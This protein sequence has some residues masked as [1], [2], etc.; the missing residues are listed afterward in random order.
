MGNCCSTHESRPRK[1]LH[2][3]LPFSNPIQYK[4]RTQLLNQTVSSLLAERDRLRR[5]DPS[6]A[7]DVVVSELSYTDPPVRSTT[8]EAKHNLHFST[9]LENTLWSKENLINLAV[10]H[11]CDSDP[12]AQYFAWVD[13]DIT[14]DSKTWVQDTIQLLDSGNAHFIQ[15]FSTA[16]LLDPS[17]HPYQT[18]KGFAYQHATHGSEKYKSVPNAHEEYWHPGFAW[19]TTRSTFERCGGL[20]ERSLGSADR[21][22]AMAFL[23]KGA[24]SVP[25]G[26]SDV[27]LRLVQEWETRV[28]DAEFKLG[29][30]PGNIK[31]YWHGDLKNR[32]YMERW[33]ILRKH[34]FDPLRDMAKRSDGVIVWSDNVGAGFKED[35][36]AYFSQRDEDSVLNSPPVMI[37]PKAGGGG[38]KEKKKRDDK[39]KK[40]KKP[41]P[42]K[43]QLPGAMDTV[44]IGGG[45]SSS[46]SSSDREA[47]EIVEV[48]GGGDDLPGRDPAP[49]IAPAFI[50]LILD[51]TTQFP[52]VYA[53]GV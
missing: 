35:V 3:I 40:T 39:S 41:K 48:G 34:G 4:R 25:P 6:Y 12:S 26:M 50:P 21:H 44:S 23:G 24:E 43:F 29:Y 5:N 42:Y 37:V 52:G 45:S 9:T 46:R 47:Y 20:I 8:H 31:H 2:V 14:F 13:A 11:I 22:M 1:T 38:T 36:F 30:V 15:L 32:Q 18:V 33:D 53:G 7:L 28:R 49:D 51:P 19:A 17:N 10:K 27:Y 16:S